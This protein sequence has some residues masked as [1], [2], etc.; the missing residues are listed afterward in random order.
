MTWSDEKAF[1]SS[2]DQG[3][4]RHGHWHCVTPD[5]NPQLDKLKLADQHA[6]EMGIQLSRQEHLHT[7]TTSFS[8]TEPML[9]SKRPSF[10]VEQSHKSSLGGVHSRQPSSNPNLLDSFSSSR[11]SRAGSHLLSPTASLTEMVPAPPL[12]FS[13]SM[14][15][16]F[17]DSLT[18]SQKLNTLERRRTLSNMNN[19]FNGN[20]SLLSMDSVA[21]T[22]VPCEDQRSDIVEQLLHVEVDSK[23]SIDRADRH[24]LELGLL[25][26][27]Q[28][29]SSFR[30]SIANCIILRIIYQA[31]F[32]TDMVASFTPEDIPAFNALLAVGHSKKN[33]KLVIFEKKLA[34][35][36]VIFKYDELPRAPMEPCPQ[37]REVQLDNAIWD[38]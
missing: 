29:V 31:D 11:H 30:S 6:L 2:T 9:T 4:A 32:G 8:I 22:L 1:S 12:H 5:D 7:P 21:S 10:I 13:T 27:Q 20:M 15:S 26:S 34:H 33:A 28:R 38:A 36:K 37:S 18:R 14:R 17:S 24:A 16:E 35:R 23:R 25:L 19:V 3:I